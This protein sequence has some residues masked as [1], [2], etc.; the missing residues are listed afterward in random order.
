MRGE[1]LPRGTDHTVTL[2]RVVEILNQWAPIT[3][4]RG[5]R[6]YG[7]TTQIACWL[8]DLRPCP[9]WWWL[10]C[11]GTDPRVALS[12]WM[13]RRLPAPAGE[14]STSRAVIVIDDAHQLDSA[15]AGLVVDL[16]RRR[17]GLHVVAAS[18][19]HTELQSM[20][21]GRVHVRTVPGADLLFRPL[22]VTS[23]A[24]RL[25][26]SLTDEQVARLHTE[27][28][29]WPAAVRIVLDEMCTGV[30]HLP[31]TRA[32]RYLRHTVVPDPAQSR[33]IQVSMRYALAE[34]L[35]YRLIRDLADDMSPQE[36]I[37]ALEGCGYTDIRHL[38]DDVQ[39]VLPEFVRRTL[40]DHYTVAEP[41]AARDMHQ[42][43]ADW[44][45]SRPGPDHDLHA[46]QHAR[47]A[48]DWTT[49]GASWTSA[50]A[51]LAAARPTEIESVLR[52]LP[53]AVI[54]RHPSIAVV[55]GALTARHRGGAPLTQAAAAQWEFARLA[56]A[57]KPSS[58]TRMPAS[59]LLLIGAGQVVD[60]RR[61]GRVD[62]IAEVT[63]RITAAWSR[64]R[65]RGESAGDSLS[66]FY[67]QCGITDHLRLRHADASRWYKLSWRHRRAGHIS[68]GRLAASAL[69]LVEAMTG[70]HDEADIWMREHRSLGRG[71]APSQESADAIVAVATQLGAVDR[72]DAS[73]PRLSAE[74]AHA[75]AASEF[76]PFATFACAR[77]ELVFG[78]PTT[79]LGVL[80]RAQTGQHEDHSEAADALLIR[81]R[82]ELLL[83]VGQGH[84]AMRILKSA[85]A[86]SDPMLAVPLSWL[87]LLA[88][89]PA[90]ARRVAARALVQEGSTTSDRIELSLVRAIAAM[91]LADTSEARTAFEQAVSLASDSGV[92]R[93]FA[94]PRRDVMRTL[95]QTLRLTLPDT[96]GSRL[97]TAPSVYPEAVSLVR[98]TRRER[99][100]AAELQRGL[101]RDQMA[102]QMFVSINTVKKQ[103]ASMYRKLGVTSRSD[104]LARLDQF[105]LLGEPPAIEGSRSR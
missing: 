97:A 60:L 52:D 23:L 59:D 93:P 100:I 20:A 15:S 36:A 55:R 56:S 28:G 26:V 71:T 49:F 7:K 25:G 22:E 70:R 65:E 77:W 99:Q 27:F 54:R 16:V 42:R 78:Q 18:R 32:E 83:A 81:V 10:D 96:L 94:L 79:G 61:R 66:W 9:Q 50:G 45:A 34:R 72:L 44:Y 84:R 88:A 6:G 39:L 3:I 101:S 105:G 29:G 17:R 62:Q 86:S 4:V 8:R 47:A 104:A 33:L 38:A 37:D 91:R 30:E 31:I 2:P 73:T 64:R 58:L 19:G 67:L 89:N 24:R 68:G 87:H 1:W 63:D 102:E 90:D 82:A 40:R 41:E 21:D 46:L 11:S 85:E 48:E 95:Q 14:R 75:A 92:F 35:T 57:V 69:A 53:P 76:W 5:M 51:S 103:L 13:T 98:L 74:I 80:A 43:L 12:E